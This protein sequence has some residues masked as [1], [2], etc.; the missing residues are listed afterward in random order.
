MSALVLSLRWGVTY[1]PAHDQK[2]YAKSHRLAAK[3]EDAGEWKRTRNMEW[4]D[5]PD[6]IYG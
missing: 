3:A 6:G 4:K 1:V 2:Q 5:G